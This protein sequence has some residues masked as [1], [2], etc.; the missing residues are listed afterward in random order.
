M[1]DLGADTSDSYSLRELLDLVL[2]EHADGLELHVGSAPVIVL[3]GEDHH[4][5]GPALTPDGAERLFREAATSRWVRELRE[6]GR[7]EFILDLGRR[8]RFAVLARMEAG[9]VGLDVRNLAASA[10]RE[11]TT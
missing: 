1:T 2:R 9:Y 6:R 3:R 8:G 11:D 4:V 5:E 10:A 7:T